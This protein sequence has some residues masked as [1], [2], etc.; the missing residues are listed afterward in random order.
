MDTE[1]TVTPKIVQALKHMQTLFQ[2]ATGE[3]VIASD[4]GV[5]PQWALYFYLGRLVYATSNNH[6]VRRYF[7]AVRQHCP[8]ISPEALLKSTSSIAGPWEMQVLN[9]A[10][11]KNMI[12]NEQAKAILQSNIQ[13]VFYAIVDQ[14]NPQ[15][16]WNH[17]EH[18][19]FT[20]IVVLSVSQVLHGTLTAKEKWQSA[21]LGHLQNMIP[22]FT[23]DLAPVIVDLDRLKAM[24]TADALSNESYQTLV[25]LLNRQNTLLD[26]SLRMR[27][28]MIAVMRSLLPLIVDGI[29]ELIEIPDLPFPLNKEQARSSKSSQPS[30]GLIACIDDSPQ[31]GKEMKQILNQAGYAVINILDPLNGVSELLKHKPDLIFLDLIMP[32][33]NGYE[34]CTFLR[35]TT[36]FQDIPIVILTGRDG[37]ID[38]VRAKMAGSSDFLSKPPEAEKVVQIVQK[39]LV[40]KPNLP[41]FVPVEEK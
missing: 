32:N 38:R 26:L 36:A 15:T 27:R 6:R 24:V 33:T 17:C 11:H 9:S 16:S 8:E 5:P 39:Y 7:R 13:E 29:V 14:K 3:L 34:L 18:L 10:L 21:G 22:G 12:T 31:I 4:K 2:G 30:K 40:T 1:I 19:P 20:P 41:G 23:F 35:K 28:N 25:K 37:V